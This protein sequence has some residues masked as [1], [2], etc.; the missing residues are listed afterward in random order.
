MPNSIA[1]F[2]QALMDFEAYVVENDFIEMFGKEHGNIL[3]QQF[4]GKCSNSITIFYR[5]LD[6]KERKK[7]EDYFSKS[8][9]LSK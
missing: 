7:L 6:S 8:R 1:D 5:T 3:W 9:W 2:M 4:K